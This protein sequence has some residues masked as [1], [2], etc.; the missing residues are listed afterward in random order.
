M[1]VDPW[2][3]V[4]AQVPRGAGFICCPVDRDFQLSVRRNFPAIEHRRL[5]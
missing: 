3:T 4:L 2:G 1:V 5:K